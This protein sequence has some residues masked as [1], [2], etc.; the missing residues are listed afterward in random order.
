MDSVGAGIPGTLPKILFLF[1][2][3]GG[4]DEEGGIVVEVGG[5]I[6]RVTCTSGDGGTYV[7][8]AGKEET[9]GE[10]GAGE[11]GEDVEEA[12]LEVILH[13][14]AG[15]EHGSACDVV[16]TLLSLEGAGECI[17]VPVLLYAEDEIFPDG[18]S[19]EPSGPGECLIS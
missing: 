8:I 5:E 12:E 2:W 14:A 10:G 6:K 9:G 4:L 16:V 1:E 3:I 13:G 11:L 17:G 15:H 7:H 19:T 18:L